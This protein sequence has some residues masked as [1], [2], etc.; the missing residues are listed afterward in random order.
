[1]AGTDYSISYNEDDWFLED[2]F[3][4]CVS[5]ITSGTSPVLIKECTPVSGRTP[6]GYSLSVEILAQTVQA[7]GSTDGTDIP[8]AQNAWGVTVSEGK[9]VPKPIPVP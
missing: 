6:E 9:L 3:W 8:A 1:M 7:L 2:G 4:Y 5:P